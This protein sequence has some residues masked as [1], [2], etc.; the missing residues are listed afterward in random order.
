MPCQ[1]TPLSTRVNTGKPPGRMK[2]SGNE[3]FVMSEYNTQLESTAMTS[4]SAS[5]S[6]TTCGPSTWSETSG[7][8]LDTGVPLG[9]TKTTGN[10][11]HVINYN[12]SFASTSSV[13][14]S[15]PPTTAFAE[16]ASAEPVKAFAQVQVLPADATSADLSSGK[17]KGK[18][19]RV[20]SNINTL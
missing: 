5:T 1:Q 10:K 6:R 7:G 11:L 12:I 4:C 2:T 16:V 9:R 19:K 8:H 20:P 18:M 14:S 13:P 15:C 3:L 17:P